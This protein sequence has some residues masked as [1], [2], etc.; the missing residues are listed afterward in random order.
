MAGV[1]EL[2]SWTNR[3]IVPDV[4]ENLV[5]WVKTFCFYSLTEIPRVLHLYGCLLHP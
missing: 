5:L 2:R 3:W 1:V 4:Q